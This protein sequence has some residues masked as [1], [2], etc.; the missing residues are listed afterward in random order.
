MIVAAQAASSVDDAVLDQLTTWDAV[1]RGD[2]AEPLIFMAWLRESVRA[3]Y[4]DDLGPAFA[5]FF[6][7]RATAMIRL[8]EG[9]TTG[10]DWCDDRSTPEREKCGDILARALGVAL[11]DL[12]K[13]YGKDRSKWRWDVAHYAQGE[14]RPFG[15]R[16]RTGAV[17]Q[18]RGAEPGG[19]T[20]S[21]AAS[22]SSARNR[23]S[24]T[25]TARACA[26][27]TTSPIWSAP[28]SCRARGSRATRCRRFYRSFAKRW[29]DGDYI[30]IPTAARRS[31]RSPSARGSWRRRKKRSADFG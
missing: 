8:L 2:A 22:P 18:H 21:T 28:C 3:I 5:R 17:L 27:S 9:R 31:T 24:P 10:R 4:S 14:H 1:M 26:P 19:P 20:R 23:R 25:G 7:T 15:E 30:E 6:D 29:A 12:E 16:A 13:R 11:A